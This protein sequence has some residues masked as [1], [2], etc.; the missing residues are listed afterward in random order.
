MD[1]VFNQEVNEQYVLFQIKSEKL[2]KIVIVKNGCLRL[3]L[4]S[5]KKCT[6]DTWSNTGELQCI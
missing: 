1:N 6:I 2:I 4:N 3:L 5:L